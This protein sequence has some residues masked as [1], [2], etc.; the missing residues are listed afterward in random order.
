MVSFSYMGGLLIALPLLQKGYEILV[1]YV[2]YFL[3]S[4]FSFFLSLSTEVLEIKMVL[5]L[6][7]M[8]FVNIQLKETMFILTFLLKSVQIHSGCIK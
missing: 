7:G 8:Y 1:G 4:L 3:F 2:L 5:Y 6:S